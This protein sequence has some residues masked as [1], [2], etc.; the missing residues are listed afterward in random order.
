MENNKDILI[1]LQNQNKIAQHTQEL[2]Q[3][4]HLRLNRLPIQ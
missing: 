2:N 1:Y 3:F 4:S